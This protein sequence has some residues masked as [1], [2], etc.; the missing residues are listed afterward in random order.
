MKIVIN[1]CYGGFGLSHEGM[2]RYAEIKG[3]TLYPE[4]D[5]FGHFT[6]WKIP[7]EQRIDLENGQ[8]DNLSIDARQSYN[9]QWYEQ[10]VYDRDIDRTDS[11]LVQVVEELGKLSNGMCADLHVVSIPDD[12]E[13]EIEEYDGTEWVAEKHRRWV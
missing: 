9:R 11:A 2:M 3:F 12:V 5:Q 4:K 10:T 1:V 8:W 7:K 13:W 6:Y